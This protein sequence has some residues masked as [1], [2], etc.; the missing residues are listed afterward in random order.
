M[1]DARRSWLHQRAAR[2]ITSQMPRAFNTV[3]NPNM[4]WKSLP[5]GKSPAPRAPMGR[6]FNRWDDPGATGSTSAPRTSQNTV[7]LTCPSR[8]DPRPI[9]Q[10]EYSTHAAI[11][12]LLASTSIRK[13]GDSTPSH[14]PTNWRLG[15]D[16]VARLGYLSRLLSVLPLVGERPHDKAGRAKQGG[17]SSSTVNGSNPEEVASGSIGTARGQAGVRSKVGH[18]EIN[19]RAEGR[20]R[21][22][23]HDSTSGV[24]RHGCSAAT[25]RLMSSPGTWT[26]TFG[27]S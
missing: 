25:C 5:H 17:N 11:R 3:V 6:R 13:D 19:R 26:N 23:G 7:C 2:W 12:Q 14:S 4:E 9:W 20:P 15:T 22:L 10:G 27:R 21:R 8:G 18:S 16:R 24:R 1:R